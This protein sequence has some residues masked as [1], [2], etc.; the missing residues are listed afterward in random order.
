VNILIVSQYF[1]PE[2][3]R[4]NDLAIGL[5]ERGHKVTVLTGIP[6]YPNGKFFSGYGIGKKYEDIYCGIKI[7]RVPLFPRRESKGWQL[8]INYL[9]FM[10]FASL[11]APIF[12]RDQYDLIFVAQ[13]SPVTVGIPA[14]ILKKIRK[15]PILFWIQDLWP[16]SL[17][18][19]GAVKSKSVLRM[20]EK[21]VKFIYGHC[22]HILVQSRGFISNV[23]SMGVL[24]SEVSYFPNWAE[25]LYRPMKLEINASEYTQLPQG[26][27]VMFAGNIGA[28]QD[29]ENILGAVERLKVY[30]DIQVVVLGDGRMREWVEEQVKVRGLTQQ[31]HLLGQYPVEKMPRFFALADVMLVT[32]KSQ[33]IFALTIPS[34]VQSYLACGKPMIAALEGEGDKVIRES[35]AGMVCPPEN[36][37]A[38]AETILAMYQKTA[39]ERAKMG[40]QGRRYFETHFE[41]EM[42]LNKLE[43][44]MK[45][46]MKNLQ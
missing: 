10:I 11:L 40:E 28:A 16:E 15:I 41:R 6:N 9:S 27:K 20:V 3:F 8:A 43:G 4:I 26:F 2:T 31:V 38:L 13:F 17:S 36:S 22:D 12:C 25:E 33:P 44:C 45:G 1:W 46:C 42:L 39:A 19:T 23:V 37:T 24:S 32:L 35:G 34:K 30:P 14:I 18:A 29:F 21:V 5:V 7:K